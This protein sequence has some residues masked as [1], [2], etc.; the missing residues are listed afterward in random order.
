[1]F[2]SGPSK[3]GRKSCAVAEEAQGAPAVALGGVY[4]G[5]VEKGEQAL[6]SL[7]AYGPPAADI[8]QP[9]PFTAAASMA[10]FLFP[11]GF[12]NYW[13]SGFLTELSDGAID[14]VVEFYQRVPS[15]MTVIVLEHN[16]DGAMSRVFMPP[17]NWVAAPNPISS[18]NTITTLG[19]PAGAFTENAGGAV[20]F[21]ASISVIFGNTGSGTGK[22]VRST[23]PGSALLVFGV[24]AVACG[25]SELPVQPSSI[26]DKLRWTDTRMFLLFIVGLPRRKRL[27]VSILCG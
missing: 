27:F 5:S 16:G 17:P 4:T 24:C 3:S 26:R 25:P 1:M 2:S 21:L 20:A 23:V 8:F 11:T 7:R 6:S 13:K 14:T 10:D 19:A 22:T 12:L 15:P 9:M 18:I